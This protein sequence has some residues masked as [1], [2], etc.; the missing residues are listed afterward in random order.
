M[1]KIFV[2]IKDVQL[3]DDGTIRLIYHVV[4]DG[5]RSDDDTKDYGCDHRI[6]AALSLGENIETMK[7]KVATAAVVRGYRVSKGDVITFGAPITKDTVSFLDKTNGITSD[8]TAVVLE[9][10]KS[11]LMARALDKLSSLWG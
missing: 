7:E 6:D 9:S 11:N 5:A 4:V 8:N 3:D 10:P 2:C 1:E